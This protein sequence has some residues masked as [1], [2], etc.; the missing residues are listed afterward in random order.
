[1]AIGDVFKLSLEMTFTGTDQIVNTFHYRQEAV[2]IGN[3]AED[4]ANQWVND[5][6]PTYRLFLSDRIVLQV[7][8][9][10]PIPPATNMADAIVGLNGQ[11][12]SGDIV[13]LSDAPIVTWRTGQVGRS[14][15][16]RTYLP[17]PQES[18]QDGGSINSTYKG[19]ITDWADVN[20][21]L[22]ELAVVQWQQV[23]WSETLAEAT[24][25]T[26]YIVRDIMGDQRR[27]RQGVG[28]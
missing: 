10:R 4:L 7:V 2:V 1:M 21:Q 9:V 13:P 23:I 24:P 17:P 12:G 15:R 19:L 6:F 14:R 5:V 18:V 16:G 25:V 20:M 3:P 11:H 26:T 27:R 22:L 8:T 28:S